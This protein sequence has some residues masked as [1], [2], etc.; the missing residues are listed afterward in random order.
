MNIE[1]NGAP[2]SVGVQ[3]DGLDNTLTNLRVSGFETGV[4]LTRPG[5]LMHN[6]HV[7]YIHSD[8]IEYDR[9]KGFY[10]TSGGNWYDGCVSNDYRTAFFTTAG[11]LS[12]YGGCA[13]RW[14]ENRGTQYAIETDGG[15]KA[16]FTEL[17]A[18]FVPGAN[19][20]LLVTYAN[21]GKG[22]VKN[23]IFNS[24]LTNNDTYKKY[25]VGNVVW[26]N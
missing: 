17:R 13:A 4:R 23:P 9:T 15:L 24:E 10:D 21:G 1:G 22:I 3:I 16:T 5:N 26:N 25:L 19:C 12:L 2:G 8:S 6:I 11:S 14:T 20:A 18:D 7:S